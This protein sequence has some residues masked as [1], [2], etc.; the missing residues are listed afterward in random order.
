[1]RND[2]IKPWYL[3]AYP[4]DDLGED[5]NEEATFK[6]LIVALKNGIDI[7]D[8]LGVSDSIIRER[9]FEKLAEIEQVT[10]DAIYNQWLVSS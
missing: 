3:E 7:Y 10:Y 5:L 9:F 8:V 6:D 4:T 1:M 2:A